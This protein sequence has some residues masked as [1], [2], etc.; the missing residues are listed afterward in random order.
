MTTGEHIEELKEALRGILSE[1]TSRM[2][3]IE[4]DLSTSR[5]INRARMEYLEKCEADRSLLERVARS[6]KR[7]QTP[8]ARGKSRTK[9]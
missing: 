3:A 7:S 8:I 1:L 9:R 4:R 2:D 5:S 6:M